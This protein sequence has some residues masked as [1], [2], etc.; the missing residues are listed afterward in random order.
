MT[1]ETYSILCWNCRNDFD[2]TEAVWCNC[3]PKLPSKVCPF[4]LQCFCP[5]DEEYKRRFWDD[6]PEPLKKELSTLEQGVDRLGDIL[7]RKQKLTTSQ[8]LEA[9]AKQKKTGE[10]LGKILIREKFLTQVDIEQALHHQSYRFMVATRDLA[11]TPAPHTPATTPKEI[12][13]NLLNLGANKGATDL[14]IEAM[15]NELSVK[16]R[17][18]GFVY[19]TKPLPRSSLKPLHERIDSLFKLD[20]AK[21][22]LPQKGR[23]T[24]KLLDRDFDLLVQTLPT[25]MGTSFNIKL[26]DRRYFIKNF[27]A[28]GLSPAD[29]L[30]LVQALDSPSGLIL[31]TSPPYNGAVTT[32]Y[33]LMDNL[34]KSDRRVVSLEPSIQWEVPYVHQIE[35]DQEKGLDYASTLR[36]ASKVNPDVMFLLELGDKATANLAAQFA[37]SRLVIAT[38][39]AFSAALSVW[40]LFELVVSPSA[41]A[42]AISLVLSQRLVRRICTNC[43]DEGHVADQRRLSSYGID[44]E[45]SRSLMLY[46]GQGCLACNHIGFRRRKGIYEVMPVDKELQA[47]LSKKPTLQDIESA[48]R[49]TGMETLREK[50]LKDIHEGVTSIEEFNRWRL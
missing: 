23:T 24:T 20:P 1:I 43:R 40:H 28:L 50:C 26:V 17:I 48:A 14:L 32:C 7:I 25:Q 5:A 3:D 15:W 22:R 16:F 9:L 21:R 11:I 49:E 45:E 38:F 13:N 4:C 47:I 36:S 46:Q 34:A 27:T 2:A 19:K 29:Q 39:P 41:F 33:S 37:S 8:L 18:D 35:V 42:P 31:V 10:L 30:L 6:A 44:A 12:L